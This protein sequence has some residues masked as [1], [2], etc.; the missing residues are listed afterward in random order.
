MTIQID[1]R[2]HLAQP[3]ILLRNRSSGRVMMRWSSHTVRQW[4]ENG[5]ICYAD[6]TNS[7]YDWI[8]L[9]Q[10]TR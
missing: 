2:L 1:A 10:A 7:Q 9:L 6:F 5:D 3:E 8:E 4:L